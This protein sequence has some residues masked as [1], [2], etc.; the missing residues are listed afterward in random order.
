MGTLFTPLNAILAV[1][2][3]GRTPVPRIVITDA[4]PKLNAIGTLRTKNTKKYPNIHKATG[5]C[6]PNSTGKK[7]MATTTAAAAK[8]MILHLRICLTKDCATLKTVRPNPIGSIRYG[9]MYGIRSP[10]V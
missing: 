4:R 3:I 9:I 6:I 7:T 1:Y 10:A 5:N 8:S 2:P